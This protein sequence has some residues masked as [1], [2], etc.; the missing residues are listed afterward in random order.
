[1]SR[2]CGSLK[3]SQPYG[4]PQPVTGIVLPFLPFISKFYTEFWDFKPP[5]RNRRCHED[6]NRI[7][8]A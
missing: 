4:P 1:L 7:E 2:K 6:A 5:E 3:I 8:L